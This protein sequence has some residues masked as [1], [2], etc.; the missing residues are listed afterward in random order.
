MRGNIFK[1]T[2]SS[3]DVAKLTTLVLTDGNYSQVDNENPLTFEFEKLLSKVR[4]DLTNVNRK[5]DALVSS[6][7]YTIENRKKGCVPS[8]THQ[9]LMARRRRALETIDMLEHL[10]NVHFGEGCPWCTGY[11][12]SWVKSLQVLHWHRKNTRCTSIEFLCECRQNGQREII[13]VL[14]WHEKKTLDISKYIMWSL[15]IGL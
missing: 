9:V 1:D 6:R 13:Y 10:S 11:Q 2:R 4:T 12:E 8:R 5:I 15:A 14:H 7:R 3:N